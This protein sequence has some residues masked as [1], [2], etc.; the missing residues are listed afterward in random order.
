[1]KLR[2][3]LLM[4]V[5]VRL[6]AQSTYATEIR[7]TVVDARTALPVAGASVAVRAAADS[8]LA[9]AAVTR[10]DGTFRVVGVRP[11]TYALRIA[12]LGYG[13]APAEAALANASARADVG[14]VRLT[15]AAVALHGVTATAERAAV[16]MAADRTSYPA[17]PAPRRP[18]SAGS[19]PSRWTRRGAS[20]CAAI[21]AWWCRS[22]GARRD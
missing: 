21:P 12:S 10:A 14:L 3:L 19:P 18:C 9:G 8:A 2:I 20:R 13:V 4:M 6:A 17:P 7:G 11:G 5:P 1:M 22:T 16:T 15:P